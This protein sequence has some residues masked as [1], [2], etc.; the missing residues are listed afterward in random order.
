[1]KPKRMMVVL[2][3]A[4]AVFVVA[5]MV[6]SRGGPAGVLRLRP[7]PARRVLGKGDRENMK[8]D[9]RA[10]GGVKVRT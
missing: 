5:R 2:A 8:R 4:V 10:V 9:L 3:L 7:R 1:M 6:A